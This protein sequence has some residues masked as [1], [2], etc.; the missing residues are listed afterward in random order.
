MKNISTRHLERK[1]EIAEEFNAV[2]ETALG[3]QKS[4]IKLVKPISHYSDKLDD[5]MTNFDKKYMTKAN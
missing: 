5:Y 2:L 3:F 4:G 1:A